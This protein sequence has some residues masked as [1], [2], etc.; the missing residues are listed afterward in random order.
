MDVLKPSAE[1]ES[2]RAAVTRIQKSAGFRRSK[3][4]RAFL[5]YVVEK[6]AEGA[7]H[8]LKEYSIGVD[9]FGR[10][11]DYEPRLDPIVRV[12]ARNLR[13]RLR[14]YYQT[15]G[16]DAR[17]VIEMPE[18]AYIPRITIGAPHDPAATTVAL[19][20]FTGS[21]GA[22]PSA[23]FEQGLSEAVIGAL[24][25]TRQ[26]RV[27]A[28]ASSFSSVLT[29]LPAPE[30][31]RRLQATHL[32]NGDV[33]AD[34]GE[35]IVRARL[36]VGSSGEVAWSETFRRP[37][38][39]VSRLPGDIAEAV[40]A[41]L[42]VRPSLEERSRILKPS[43][44]N[45]HS[46]HACLEGWFNF[47]QWSQAGLETARAC[48]EDATRHDPDN[49][50]AYAGLAFTWFA[51]GNNAIIDAPK[52]A[53]EARTWAAKAVAVDS[54]VGEAH[55]VLASTV[56]AFEFQWDEA[57]REFRESIRLNP[58]F[59]LAHHALAQM[60]L[61]PQR[62]FDEAVEAMEA[63]RRLDPLSVHILGELGLTYSF[64][65]R[66]QDARE[67]LETALR[68]HDDTWFLHQYLGFTL[69]RLGRR[70]DAWPYFERA[71]ELNPCQ[72]ARA[73]LAYAAARTGRTARQQELVASVRDDPQSSSLLFALPA[74]GA[75]DF[76][77][78]FEH[79]HR[80]AERREPAVRY[81]CCG[82]GI[83][84]LWRDPRFVP[85][86][87]KIGLPDPLTFPANPQIV[88]ASA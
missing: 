51:L 81:A 88:R 29:A 70:E 69:D 2:I 21:A 19:L 86:R 78:A 6:A 4:L 82:F 53:R 67:I 15:E 18:G 9:V 31:A 85:L 47:H 77:T 16:R 30:I 46:Y 75:G 14:N 48:F 55:A 37:Q 32:L 66:F 10:S 79:L 43:T 3:Q 76:D 50:S 22:T 62:R 68:L 40:I 72:E 1:L 61:L 12:Q 74:I 5:V 71:L 17:V 84:H 56:A 11:K 59:A 28:R 87:R 73:A 45:S 44:A 63:A 41:A 7:H 13:L 83:E 80:A 57:E 39:S 34:D 58:S 60:V 26:L 54:G 65:E 27:I 24:S 20:P 36:V 38:G 25:M 49:A 23:H 52:A 42:P 35:V 64:A 33:A 8:E